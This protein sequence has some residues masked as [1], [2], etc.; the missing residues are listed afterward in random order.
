M[1]V[2]HDIESEYFEAHVICII[3]WMDCLLD[4]GKG[5]IAG[6]HCFDDDVVDPSLESVHIVAHLFD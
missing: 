6:D 4:L 5:R 1:V 3:V 2:Q